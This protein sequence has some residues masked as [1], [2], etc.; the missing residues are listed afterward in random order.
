M[1]TGRG[2]VLL[3]APH[4]VPGQALGGTLTHI[5]RYGCLY[6]SCAHFTSHFQFCLSTMM[7]EVLGYPETSAHS[8]HAVR[9]HVPQ[10]HSIRIFLLI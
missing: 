10:K 9:R 2:G 5:V 3:P 7:M 4:T 6:P 8:Y 1:R